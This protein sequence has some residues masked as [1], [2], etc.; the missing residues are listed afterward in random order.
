MIALGTI[1]WM[2]PA[3][4]LAGTPLLI[5]EEAQRDLVQNTFWWGNTL[6]ATFVLYDDGLV[7]FRTERKS[8]EVRSSQLTRAALEEWTG[9]IEQSGFP[10]LRESYS[11][12]LKLEQPIS[13]IKYRHNGVIRRIAVSGPMRESKDRAKAPQAFVELFDRMVSFAP[14]ESKIWEPLRVE[15]RIS[16]FMK[17]AGK[18]LRWPKGLPGL[19]DSST[20]KES[21][22]PEMYHLHLEG[23]NRGKLERLLASRKENQAVAIGGRLWSVYPNRYCLP[24]EEQWHGK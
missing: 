19:T 10:D 2:M 17:P 7:L 23:K 14:V 4:V 3:G 8:K 12:N 24:G 16:P 15:V 21:I 18:P 20:K 9:L 6:L 11:L 1:L 13:V 5:L 22:G